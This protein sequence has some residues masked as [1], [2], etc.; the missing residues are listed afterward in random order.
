MVR[1]ETAEQMAEAVRTE[2]PDADVLVMAAAVADFRPLD[3]A[4]QKIRRANAPETIAL[5][6]APDILGESRSESPE[7]RLTVGFALETGNGLESARRK[8]AEKG[9]DLIVLNEVGE[10]AGF[11]VDTNRVVLIDRDGGEEEIE[12]MAKTAL[13]EILLDRIEARLS[14][15]GS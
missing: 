11:D 8:L 9:L 1:V 3:P 15:G 6:P 4:R 13:A 10:D 5:E 12:L 2:L 7:R 14:G